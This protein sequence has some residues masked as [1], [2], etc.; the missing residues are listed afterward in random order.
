LKKQ[1]DKYLAGTEK[2]LYDRRS[3]R[4]V[5]FEFFTIL[6][7]IYIKE[8]LGVQFLVSHVAITHLAYLKYQS[9]N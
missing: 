6:E 5:S 4:L 1:K 2:L 7:F 3:A 8:N 9:A